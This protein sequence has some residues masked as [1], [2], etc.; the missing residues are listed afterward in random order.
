MR[1]ITI[2]INFFLLLYFHFSSFLFERCSLIFL[3]YNIKI[4]FTSCTGDGTVVSDEGIGGAP[5]SAAAVHEGTVLV[6]AN[7]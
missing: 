6:V 1:C 4:V 7:E 3:D 2:S 5:T